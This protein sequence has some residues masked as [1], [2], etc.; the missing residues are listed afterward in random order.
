MIAIVFPHGHASLAWQSRSH[1]QTVLAQP[2][3]YRHLQAVGLHSAHRIDAPR[4]RVNGSTARPLQTSY[5]QTY[6]HGR[7]AVV[8]YCTT[9]DAQRTSYYT[10]H[11][12]SGRPQIASPPKRPSPI[13][14]LPPF[15]PVGRDRPGRL[16]SW[17]GFPLLGSWRRH[18]VRTDPTG[19]R[20]PGPDG[21]RIKTKQMIF[22]SCLFPFFYFLSFMGWWGPPASQCMQPNIALFS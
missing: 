20:T 12:S 4:L 8:N 22:S 5:E 6:H 18:R 16:G 14:A 19:T 11:R 7:L 10:D 9:H 2:P 15:P 13:A 1:L 21:E 17:P 3:H